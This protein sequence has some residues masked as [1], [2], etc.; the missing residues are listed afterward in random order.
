MD[1]LTPEAE[2]MR[3][4]YKGLSTEEV[5]ARIKNPNPEKKIRFSLKTGYKQ[6]DRATGGLEG[7]R[8]Y[9]LGG[10]NKSGKSTL[11]MNIANNM[12]LDQTKV[13]YIDTELGV[14]DFVRRLTAISSQV[15]E[16]DESNTE[17]AQQSFRDVYMRS[18]QLWYTYKSDLVVNGLF[19]L[20]KT[21]SLFDMW[22]AKG[23]QIVFFDNITTVQNT[24]SGNRS[25]ND[26]LRRYVDFLIGYAR[27]NNIVLVLILHTKG[28]ELKYSESSEKIARLIDDPDPH[29]IFEKTVTVNTKP[30]VTKL[31]GGQAILSQV[32]GG[33][34]LL[35]RPY[36]D[37]NDSR[38]QRMAQLILEDFRSKPQEFVNEIE[39][40]YQANKSLYVEVPNERKK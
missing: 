6:L 32:S 7:R 16:F 20:A 19:D 9:I 8:T 40:D 36:Q 12:L 28:N 15:H 33:V 2:K 29:K 37:Y 27:E 10:L 24:A 31:Y 39:L 1:N 11:S 23:V 3:T 13:G 38:Y 25:G 4:T 18:G 14:E 35:W 26:L 22:R 17:E 34:L 5:V 21:E 30:S